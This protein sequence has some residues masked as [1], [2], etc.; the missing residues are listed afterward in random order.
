M[1][2]KLCD[3][4]STS[5]NTVEMRLVARSAVSFSLHACTRNYNA[6]TPLS[7][8]RLSASCTQAGCL[9]PVVDL[10]ALEC[11]PRGSQDTPTHLCA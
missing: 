11:E 3:T 10:L 5:V 1:A 8:A 2:H 9:V 7:A 6:S 4:F